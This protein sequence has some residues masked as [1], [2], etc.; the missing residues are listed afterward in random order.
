MVRATLLCLLLVAIV[1]MGSLAHAEDT[2]SGTNP[3]AS[4]EGSTTGSDMGDD[5]G[6]PADAPDAAQGRRPH[7]KRRGGKRP[8]LSPECEQQMKALHE[9]M[10]AKREA[11]M[12][13][14]GIT[15]GPGKGKRE[16]FKNMSPACKEKMKALHQEMKAKRR[17]IMQRCVGPRPSPGAGAPPPTTTT[18]PGAQ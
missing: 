18:Q 14:C 5:D 2:S 17:A 11:I 13:E 4:N 1:A 12:K 15:P 3:P 8:K 6:G 9:E 10:K 7:G 16:A